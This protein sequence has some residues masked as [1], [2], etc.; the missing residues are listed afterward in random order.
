MKLRPLP[1]SV[2][3]SL[4][5]GFAQTYFLMFVWGYLALYSPLLEWLLGLGLRGVGLRVVL[6]P[7]DFLTNIVL[8]LPAAF[9]LVK[10]R[11]PRLLLF[12]VVAV[13]PW[14]VWFNFHLVGSSTFAEF[15]PSFI[16]GWVQELFALPAAAY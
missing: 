15:W 14:F 12:L 10:L 16:F 11:P 8:S 6:Y 3:T 1:F 4:L 5:L 9:V 7:I 2:L 13:V